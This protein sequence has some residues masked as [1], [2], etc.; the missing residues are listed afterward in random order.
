[1]RLISQ[2][3]SSALVQ[4]AVNGGQAGLEALLNDLINGSIGANG[5]AQRAE[6]EEQIVWLRQA[7]DAEDYA[8]QSRILDSLTMRWMN[9]HPG[10]TYD[11][12]LAEVTD[13]LGLTVDTNHLTRDANGR[14]T[15][16]GSNVITPVFDD[17]GNLMPGV[18]DPNASESEQ[19]QQIADRLRQLG[20]S[21]S[22]AVAIAN[23]YLVDRQARLMI[24]AGNDRDLAYDHDLSEMDVFV[25]SED[26]RFEALVRQLKRDFPE[27]S[28]DV[29]RAAA[30][31]QFAARNYL[32][33]IDFV[34]DALD[35]VF[36]PDRPQL[37]RSELIER[38]V[39]GAA[40]AGSFAI[41]AA[42]GIYGILDAGQDSFRAIANAIISDDMFPGAT[43]RNEARAELAQRLFE[44]V[45]KLPEA[46]LQQV[47]RQLAEADRLE[48]EGDIIGASRVRGAAIAGVVTDI[49][50]SRGRG[51]STIQNVVDDAQALRAAR[52]VEAERAYAGGK[53]DAAWDRKPGAYGDAGAALRRELGDP[54]AGMTKP[55]AHHLVGFDR[56]RDFDAQQILNAASITPNS[57]QNGLYLPREVHQMTFGNDYR[58][59]RDNLL[60]RV[61]RSEVP[62]TL[63]GIKDIL[64]NL[65]PGDKPPPPASD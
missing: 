47:N 53:P 26:A 7:I 49:L 63:D 40:A 22:E 6:L 4:T 64:R 17:D 48:R 60:S 33:R 1:L 23:D 12:A 57:A 61:P 21:P 2:G 10:T 25:Q 28:D 46:Y 16:A 32:G 65:Q 13:Q 5:N 27:L 43:E 50:P 44:N 24:T 3:F 58:L 31:A 54:P 19:Q 45:H 15:V 52:R 39:G 51:Q 37:T 55:E 8:T 29:I 34:N 9:N 38:V 11:Q 56:D 30:N 36:D 18:V 41:N 14:L 35:V 59:W 62:R 42:A 20:F